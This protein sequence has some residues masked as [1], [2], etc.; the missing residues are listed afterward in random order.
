MSA[1]L[2][3]MHIPGADLENKK[4]ALRYLREYLASDLATVLNNVPNGKDLVLAVI[5]REIARD[6]LP[7]VFRWLGQDD[8]LRDV[9][10]IG[11]GDDVREVAALSRGWWAVWWA[12]HYRNDPRGLDTSMLVDPDATE[13]DA[14]VRR[15]VRVQAV[16]QFR[17]LDMPELECAALACRVEGGR[18]RY[19]PTG[20]VITIITG[21][22]SS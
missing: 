13:S 20:R 14:S 21:P 8:Q 6:A 2:P 4:R 15:M 16:K 22:S 1:K 12:I 17:A 7:V 5:D 18:V 3:K 9:F 19:T 11:R 10:A